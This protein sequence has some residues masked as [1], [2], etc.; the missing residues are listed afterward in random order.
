M[1]RWAP[2]STCLGTPPSWPR[3]A[4]PAWCAAGVPHQ[5]PEISSPLCIYSSGLLASLATLYFC[6]LPSLTAMHAQSRQGC[7]PCVMT[8]GWQGCCT[9]AQKLTTEE[10][11]LGWLDRLA[12]DGIIP[13]YPAMRKEGKGEGKAGVHAREE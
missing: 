5:P 7:R 4:S 3:P 2:T 9:T 13:D 12:K 6:L 8:S 10:V 11:F 1:Q